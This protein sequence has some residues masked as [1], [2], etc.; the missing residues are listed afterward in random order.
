MPPGRDQADGDCEPEGGADRRDRL[1]GGQGDRADRYQE[2]TDRSYQPGDRSEQPGPH[3]HR[4]HQQSK[5][6]DDRDHDAV[7]IA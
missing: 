6:N 3:D 4:H 5:D 7:T 1:A 2:P